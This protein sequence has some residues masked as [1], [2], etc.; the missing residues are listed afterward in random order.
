[1][2]VHASEARTPVSLNLGGNL[3]LPKANGAAFG[4]QTNAFP[5]PLAEL[6]PSS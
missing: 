1:M 4:M 2:A 5:R 3:P 6:T